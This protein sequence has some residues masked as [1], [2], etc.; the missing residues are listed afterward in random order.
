M[1]KKFACGA[2]L[3]TDDKYG[4][5]ISVQGDISE[6]FLDFV[7]TDLSKYNIPHAKISFEEG[8]KK[9]PKTEE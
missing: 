6:R 1:G 2:S 8:K 9:K 4:E 5:C 7:D 3:A